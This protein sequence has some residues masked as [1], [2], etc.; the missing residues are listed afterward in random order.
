MVLIPS[1]DEHAASTQV[2]CSGPSDAGTSEVPATPVQADK[3]VWITPSISSSWP[4]G[5]WL[6]VR[7]VA[8]LAPS[9]VLHWRLIAPGVEISKRVS[10]G[11]EV[12]PESD[13]G[14]RMSATVVPR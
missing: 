12:P 13:A 14:W 2:R 1:A 8:G 5:S 11:Q 3:E 7:I 10:C 9:E 4:A 6:C